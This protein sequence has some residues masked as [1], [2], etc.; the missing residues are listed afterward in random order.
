MFLKTYEESCKILKISLVDSLND[1]KLKSTFKQLAIEHHPDKKGGD[2]ET[3]KKINSAHDYIKK[4]QEEYIKYL[5]APR[6]YYDSDEF[7]E[8]INTFN[9]KKRMKRR[10]SVDIVI[11]M[12]LTVQEINDTFKTMVMYTRRISCEECKNEGC[13]NCGNIGVLYQDVMIEVNITA[14]VMNEDGNLVYYTFGDLIKNLPMG[15]LIIKPIYKKGEEFWIEKIENDHPA[16]T[17][18]LKLYSTDANSTV[19]VETV[20][21]KVD[22][23]LP[24]KI[25]N[26]QKIRIKGKGLQFKNKKGDHYIILKTM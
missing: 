23:K 17:S 20:D 8:S 2:E 12:E 21:G 26:N 18:E 6:P 9:V 7:V 15:N 1:E 19:R 24:D 16:V 14:D 22:V 4:H 10:P 25:K 3:F 11:D 5:N 13:S